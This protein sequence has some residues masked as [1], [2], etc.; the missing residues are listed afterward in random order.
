M[1][2][3]AL[4]Q[5]RVFNRFFTARLSVF[6]RYALGTAYSLVEGRSIGKIGRNEGCMANTIAEGLNVIK[7]I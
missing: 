5:V 2:D 6:N 7:A 4:K 3:T 1:E